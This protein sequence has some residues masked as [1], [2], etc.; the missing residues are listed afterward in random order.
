[1][2]PEMLFGIS[3]YAIW[4][5]R[6]GSMVIFEVIIMMSIYWLR[7]SANSNSSWKCILL[8]IKRPMCYDHWKCVIKY[9]F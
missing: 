6:H 9:G 3:V 2:I 7:I 8:F 1:M 5:E 4:Y